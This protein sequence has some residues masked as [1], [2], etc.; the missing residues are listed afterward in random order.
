MMS[1]RLR[2][3]LDELSAYVGIVA[4]ESVD[5]VGVLGEW[6]VRRGGDEGALAQIPERERTQA[7]ERVQQNTTGVTPRPSAP[8]GSTTTATT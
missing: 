6:Y 4:A 3:R 8:T 5:G 1:E 2:E 7:R